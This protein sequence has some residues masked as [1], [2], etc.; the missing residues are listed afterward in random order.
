MVEK[1][2]SMFSCPLEKE[3]EREKLSN[4]LTN[5][6]Q[7]QREV[8]ILKIWGDL[9]FQE[10]AEMFSCS[11]NTVTSRYRYATQKLHNIMKEYYNE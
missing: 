5:L 4:A 2:C 9:T 6:P 7:D 10:I 11:I 1:D 8:I 3:E